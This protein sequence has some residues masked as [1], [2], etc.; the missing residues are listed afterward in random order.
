[1][2]VNQFLK[3]PPAAKRLTEFFL[4]PIPYTPADIQMR[5]ENEAKT[6][7]SLIGDFKIQN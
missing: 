7:G 4:F 1:M 5:A 6:W 3:D 2:A